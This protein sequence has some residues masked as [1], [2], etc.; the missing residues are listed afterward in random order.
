MSL[1]AFRMAMPLPLPK[2]TEQAVLDGLT[3]RWIGPAE[4][5]RWDELMTQR[6]YLKN[7]RLV[8]EQLR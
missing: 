5:P 6:H 4:Q 8:G 7:A 3:V 2:A 1:A